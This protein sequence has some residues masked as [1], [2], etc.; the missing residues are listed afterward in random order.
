MK[1]LFKTLFYSALALLLAAIPAALLAAPHG[2]AHGF[3]GG[4]GPGAGGPFARGFF[5]EKIADRLDLSDDQR[6]EIRTIFESYREEADGL[7]ETMRVARQGL[8]EQ[9]Q[10]DLFDE[11]A[12]REAADL[13]AAVEADLAVLRAKIHSD[14]GQVLTPEQLAEAKAMR[15]RMQEFAEERRGRGRWSRGFDA[16]PADGE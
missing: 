12:I 7:G 13:V 11:T 14:V 4:F 3:G 5:A 2:P 6:V 10:S 1:T 9:I 8:R 15:E 16:P